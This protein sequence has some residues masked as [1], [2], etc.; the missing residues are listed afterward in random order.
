MK[1]LRKEK[2]RTGQC[3]RVGFMT[4]LP[5]DTHARTRFLLQKSSWSEKYTLSVLGNEKLFKIK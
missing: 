3:P 5:Y 1:W 2:S 4:A